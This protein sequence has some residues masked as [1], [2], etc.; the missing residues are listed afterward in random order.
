MGMGILGMGRRI[1]LYLL[2]RVSQNLR[3]DLS[4]LAAPTAYGDSQA[5]GW[6][7]AAPAAMPQLWQCLILNPLSCAED[8]TCASAAI[9]ATAETM[10]DPQLTVPQQELQTLPSFLFFWKKRFSIVFLFFYYYF[11]LHPQHA[12][13][14]RL[15]IGPMLLQQPESR[16]WQCWILNPQCHQGTPLW[17]DFKPSQSYLW[18][19]PRKKLA[20]ENEKGQLG[21]IRKKSRRMWPGQE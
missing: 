17:R 20:Q 13:V 8:Q 1:R 9:Q 11:C 6:I 16:Q 4:F 21:D 7:W 14:P 15:G 5:R 12:E 10:L 18:D 19:W 2:K 3:R